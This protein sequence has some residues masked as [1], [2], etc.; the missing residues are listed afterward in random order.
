MS[1]GTICAP[2]LSVLFIILFEVHSVMTHSQIKKR[3]RQQGPKPLRPSHSNSAIT[4]LDLTPFSFKGLC[5]NVYLQNVSWML[6]N[7]EKVVF[8]K[9]PRNSTPLFLSRIKILVLLQ[10]RPEE[11]THLLLHNKWL[12]ASLW[13]Y[14]IIRHLAWWVNM[15]LHNSK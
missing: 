9:I 15:R 4:L 6:L 5:Y 8:F 1:T 10:R 3:Q 13:I 11:Q 12:S 14:W 7:Q 2:I